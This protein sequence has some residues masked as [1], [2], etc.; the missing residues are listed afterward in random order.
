MQKHSENGKVHMIR[1]HENTKMI[2]AA[3][4]P[5]TDESLSLLRS[6]WYF[7]Q[8]SQ[9]NFRELFILENSST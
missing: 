5:H 8:P 6:F 1:I 2:P 9:L 7:N 4:L 3:Q